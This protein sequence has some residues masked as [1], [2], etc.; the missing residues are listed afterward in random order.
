MS[1]LEQ[2]D[3]MNTMEPRMVRAVMELRLAEAQ[4]QASSRDLLRQIMPNSPGWLS[5]QRLWLLGKLGS[6]MVTWGE[7]L[8]RHGLSQA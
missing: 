7:G 1:L 4:E 5:R 6:R 8:Q 2:G 3:N